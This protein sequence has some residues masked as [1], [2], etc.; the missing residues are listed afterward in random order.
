MLNRL[1]LAGVNRATWWL[2][3]IL[4]LALASVGLF[5]TVKGLLVLGDLGGVA[6]RWTRASGD[7]DFP[8]DIA[9]FSVLI[10]FGA[11][12]WCGLGVGTLICCARYFRGQHVRPLYWITLLV[13]AILI[14]APWL[15]FKSIGAALIPRP[16][17]AF[18][19]RTA[20]FQWAIVVLLY[21]ISSVT[22]TWSSERRPLFRRT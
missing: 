7:P 18:I 3:A 20:A 4:L 5:Y 22:F 21:L 10:A 14:H 11:A 19:V 1:S 17:A 13:L 12:L 8:G 2:R 9:Q 15:L 16:D 6:D